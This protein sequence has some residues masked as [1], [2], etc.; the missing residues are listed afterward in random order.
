MLSRLWP[1]L[2][3]LFFAALFISLQMYFVPRWL[4]LRGSLDAPHQQPWRW[5]GLLP[6]VLGAA[7][8]LWCVLGFALFGKGTPAPFDAPRQLVSRGLYRYVRNP[9]YWGMAF[10]LIGEAVLIAE[11]RWAL[12]IYAAALVVIVNAFVLLYEEPTL[13]R[14]FGAAYEHYCSGVPRWIPNLHSRRSS[15]GSAPPR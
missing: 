15:G 13:K 8:M 14:Q 3:A 6:L 4:G 1:L 12:V 7:I 11:L 2:R 5:L 9:M 10:A